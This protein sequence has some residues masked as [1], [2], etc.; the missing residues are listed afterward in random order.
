MKFSYFKNIKISYWLI[1]D[2]KLFP[3]FIL[4]PEDFH[5]YILFIFV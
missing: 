2:N 3:H 5:A 4:D 1:K